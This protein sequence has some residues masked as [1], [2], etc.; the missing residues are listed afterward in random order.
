MSDTY[1]YEKYLC[2]ID[3]IKYKINK[4]GV[5][6]IP[7]VLDQKECKQM[8]NEI[9]HYFEHISKK[10][11]PSINKD[12]KET[13]PEFY[14]LYPL[15]SMLV[16]YW[17][18][19]HCQASWNVRQNPKVVN[20]FAKFWDCKP[21]DLIV[22]FDALS[23]HLP[24]EFTGKGWYNGR[25][26]YHT[27]Q[28]YTSPK[29]DCLQG[30]ITGIDVNDMDAT[31]SVFEKSNRYH[32]EF[33]AKFNVTETAN[34]YRLSQE[35]EKFYLDKG[36]KISNIKCPKGSLVLWDS[37]TIHCGIECKKERKIPNIRAVIYVCYTPR[38]FATKANLEKKRKA[39]NELRT[40]TH[41]PHK[42]KLFNKEPHTY[43]AM[44]PDITPIDPPILTD[45][46]K[47]LAGF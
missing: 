39:F 40:T 36:C 41:Y 11:N 47:K 24:P 38:S 31:L 3:T 45:L 42:I 46:G 6:I 10:W 13:W 7:S 15:H 33:A 17:S 22:S 43:G 16:Q 44:K 27:D 2:D 18:I 4:Y 26:W 29:F 9:W 14:K 32:E 21:E 28:S 8:V 37:R 34:W 30:L 12:N 20:I 35:Q 1:E 19:G 5:A 25:T 23:F